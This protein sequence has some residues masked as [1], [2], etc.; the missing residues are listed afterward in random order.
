MAVPVNSLKS[1]FHNESGNH[2][3]GTSVVADN[4]GFGSEFSRDL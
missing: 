1:T 4:V 2:F 3:I